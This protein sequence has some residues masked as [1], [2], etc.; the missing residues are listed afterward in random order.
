[1]VRKYQHKMRFFYL[2]QSLIIVDGHYLSNFRF[3]DDSDFHCGKRFL[4][5]RRV[6]MM[7]R[8]PIFDKI[9]KDYQRFNGKIRLTNRDV[10]FGYCLIVY[11]KEK[12]KDCFRQSS[13][14]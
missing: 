14:F 9:Q 8:S 13:P 5:D 12:G 10:S 4:A 6:Q 7:Q 2:F 3:P 11:P 1:M